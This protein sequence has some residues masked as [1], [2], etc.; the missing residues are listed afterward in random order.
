MITAT[1]ISVRFGGLRALEDVSVQVEPGR[2]EALIGPNGAGKS[3]LLNV[4]SGFV[5]PTSGSIQVDGTDVTR[6]AAHRRARSGI[7]R[8]FQTPRYVPHLSVADNVLLGFFPRVKGGLVHTLLGTLGQMR[9]ERQI[10]EQLDTLLEEFELHEV[11]S[12]EAGNVPLWQLRI[13]EIAR[14]M[15]ARPQYVFLDEPAAGFDDKERAL[16]AGQVSKL[17]QAGVGVLLVEHNFGF[18]KTVSSHVTVLAQGKHLASGE[19]SQ[20]DSDPRVVEVYLG[21]EEH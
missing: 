1:D 11:A 3:T 4:L 16:L 2:V 10:R 21:K 15:A 8:S 9:Q 13:M 12:E 7:A 18:I 19:P 6:A 14:C 17:T 20:I 5:R